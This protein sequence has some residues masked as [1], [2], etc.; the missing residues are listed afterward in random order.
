MLPKKFPL[1]HV[2]LILLLFAVSVNGLDESKDAT[3]PHTLAEALEQL[4][5]TLPSETLNDIRQSSES[6]M[7]QYHFGLG[8]WMRNHW[9]LWSGGP[10]YDE[11][12]GL[13]LT[14]P[15]DMSSLILTS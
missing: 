7:I 9:G 3:Q 11:L 2:P 12:H 14:H 13:G 1:L 10:L 5:T 15:D 4:E 8:T 6:D